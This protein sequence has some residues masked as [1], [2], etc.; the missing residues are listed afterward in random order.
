MYRQWVACTIWTFFPVDLS[1]INFHIIDQRRG[2]EIIK[3]STCPGTSKWPKCTCPKKI[4]L[5]RKGKVRISFYL[6]M[7]K[8]FTLS[9]TVWK[10]ADI[11]SFVNSVDPDQLASEGIHT[12]SNATCEII[13]IHQNVKYQILLTLFKICDCPRTSKLKIPTCSE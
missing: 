13:I 4:L 9:K 10:H 12:V 1:L 3:F 2:V 11:N 7:L 6:S 8:Q 5:V